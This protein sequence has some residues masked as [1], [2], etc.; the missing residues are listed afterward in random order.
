MNGYPFLDN[1]GEYPFS[2]TASHVMRPGLD[3]PGLKVVYNGHN[4]VGE[5]ETLL[6]SCPFSG[7]PVVAGPD[8]M[9]IRGFCT[10]RDLEVALRNA[11]KTHSYVTTDSK[12]FFTTDI[13]DYDQTGAAPLRL[14]K[15]MDLA[16][17]TVS[18]DQ[19]SGKM[20]TSN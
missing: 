1:K 4:T 7:F 20:S 14:R 5:L 17:I 19:N 10:R 2:T 9:L 13:P 16:P 18:S 15:A 6:R 12:V 11:R 8:S 3:M